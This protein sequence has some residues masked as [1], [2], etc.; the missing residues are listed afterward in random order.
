MNITPLG[1]E[2]LTAV[3][4]QI[5]TTTTQLL[6]SAS[7]FLA[8]FAAFTAV[9]IYVLRSSY[10]SLV[11]E[12]SDT[13]LA[14]ALVAVTTLAIVPYFTEVVAAQPSFFY[15]EGYA[16]TPNTP[17][18][19]DIVFFSLFLL[20]TPVTMVLLV[21]DE[22]FSIL[23]CALNFAFLSVVVMFLVTT[24]NVVG[25]V[26]GYELVFIPS[27][28]IMRRTVYSSS[29]LSA[30]SVFTVWSVLGSLV[31]VS[32]A[33]Y[34]IV[35]TGATAFTEATEVGALSE[36]DMTVASFLFFVGFGVKIPVWPF[37]Y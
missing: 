21:R 34:L 11:G 16:G 15:T 26:M 12:H 28:F 17:A 32:G 25:L 33:V 13:G 10:K 29:A 23:F 9:F 27:F 14:L 20:I 8:A 18:Y 36:A 7:C 19:A 5:A 3:S 1:R 30:Y 4:P 24:T 37:H 2:L 31:V 35:V 22:K 6:G